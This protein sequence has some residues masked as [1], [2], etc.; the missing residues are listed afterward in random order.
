MADI[1]NNAARG[2]AAVLLAMHLISRPFNANNPTEQ[3]DLAYITKL[4]EE[5]RLQETK[6]LLGWVPNTT[7]NLPLL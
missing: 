1:G 7:H 5:A 6:T 2:E 3:L 4:I